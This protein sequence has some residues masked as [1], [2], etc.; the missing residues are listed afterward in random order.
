GAAG[1]VRPALVTSR[2]VAPALLYCDRYPDNVASIV[3]L[4]PVWTRPD[5]ELL[6]GQFAGEIDSIALWGPRR[7]AEPGVREGFPRSGQ[8]GASPRM[9]EH[10]YPVASDEER[11]DVE[12]AASRIPVAVLVLRRPE[13]PWSPDHASDPILALLPGAVRVD[14]PGADMLIYGG[15]V[16][17]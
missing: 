2:E 4:E 15:E 12:Q 7:A 8:M 14:L 10:A 17:A 13:H 9:A 16:D 3:S 5:P 11:H 1:A 6:R